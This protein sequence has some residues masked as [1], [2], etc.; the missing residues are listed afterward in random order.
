MVP[1]SWGYALLTLAAGL[2]IPV[3]AALNSHLGTKLQNPVAAS[4]VVFVVGGL[5]CLPFVMMNPPDPARFFQA[6]HPAFYFAG[7]FAT[8]YIL[9]ITF[10]APRIGVGNAVFFVLFGQLISAAIIDHFGLLG[11]SP[12]R[13]DLNRIAGLVLMAAGVFLAKRPIDAL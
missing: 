2:G 13:I 5:A 8:L 12:V 10:V 4:M 11:A 6:A 7:V 3:L 9:S 1:P